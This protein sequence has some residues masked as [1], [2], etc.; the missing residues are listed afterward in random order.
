MAVA[1]LNH[2]IL[3]PVTINIRQN[4]S[5]VSARWKCGQ[6]NVIVPKGVDGPDIRRLLDDLTPRLLAMRPN[7][8]YFDGQQLSFPLV[9]FVVRRQTFAPSKIIGT[10]SVPVASVEVGSDYDF[11]LDSTSQAISNMLCKVARNIAP[12]VLVPR[13]RSIAESI[14][15][16]PVG[17]TISTG[18][19]VLG[20]CS[21]HGIIA[22]SYIL[23][24]LPQHLC[25]YVI[26]HELA[27]LTEMNHSERFHHLLNSYL[28]GQEAHLVKQLQTYTWPVFRK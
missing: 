19:R 15:R 2:K 13:A 23:V 16:T 28:H 6:L 8:S 17:W 4:S 7:V 18:H 9:D 26:Y 5:R 11:A 25:D 24:F 27:H 3:G 10:A 12:K 21:S 14:N 1:Q 22:L 20:Q